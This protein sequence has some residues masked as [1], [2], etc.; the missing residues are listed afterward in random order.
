MRH[1][2]DFSP[3]VFYTGLTAVSRAGHHTVSNHSRENVGP[4]QT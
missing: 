2:H 4:C 3:F 1:Y